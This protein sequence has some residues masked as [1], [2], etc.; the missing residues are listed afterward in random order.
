MVPFLWNQLLCCCTLFLRVRS[1]QHCTR[2]STTSMFPLLTARC[3]A[4]SPF[5]NHVY[6]IHWYVD[7]LKLGPSHKT[8][9]TYGPLNTNSKHFL[10]ECAHAWTNMHACLHMYTCMST[11]VHMYVYTCAHACLH[12]CTCMFLHACV[13]TCTHQSVFFVLCSLFI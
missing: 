7:S 3:N 11:H 9:T 5:W 8:T 4:V 6:Q 12:K 1:A 13:S 2:A 10:H